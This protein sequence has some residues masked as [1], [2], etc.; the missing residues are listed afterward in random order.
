MYV[1]SSTKLSFNFSKV[2]SCFYKGLY[3][4]VSSFCGIIVWKE[5]LYIHIAENF[6][7][8]Y[9]Y[10]LVKIYLDICSYLT[11]NHIRLIFI[12]FLTIMS[13]A[14]SAIMQY[15][16]F[17]WLLDDVQAMQISSASFRQKSFNCSLCLEQRST[18]FAMNCSGF[19]LKISE[20]NFRATL[21]G[22]LDERSARRHRGHCHVPS[23]WMQVLQ[24]LWLQL[25]MMGISNTSQ[26]T[27]HCRCSIVKE[28]SWAI[29]AEFAKPK[30]FL[31]CLENLQAESKVQCDWDRRV[32]PDLQ[33]F[34][35]WLLEN[36]RNVTVLLCGGQFI[37]F[38]G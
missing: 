4:F 1:S 32:C 7:K 26:H 33:T 23:V 5:H 9:R 22:G 27:G 21:I 28:H 36:V 24:K 31:R 34:K 15:S 14:A 30:V 3:L 10:T 12:R 13:D 2:V 29:G 17:L 18:D 25:S 11:T 16:W 20:A 37:Y 19:F 6:D 8:L 35:K 38:L